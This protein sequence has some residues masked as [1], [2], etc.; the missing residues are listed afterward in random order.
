MNR[1]DH[2]RFSILAALE[3]CMKLDLDTLCSK[4]IAINRITLD[5]EVMD[6]SDDIFM[7]IDDI[8]EHPTYDVTYASALI[9]YTTGEQC[10]EFNY[11][12]IN[13]LVESFFPDDEVTIE[14]R[15][16]INYEDTGEFS[17]EELDY[18]YLQQQEDEEDKTT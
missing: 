18:W 11:E 17:Q 2:L 14:I 7:T 5:V 6:E 12:E 4:V 13:S 9:E 10:Y 15:D 3:N 8:Y 16:D 1:Q